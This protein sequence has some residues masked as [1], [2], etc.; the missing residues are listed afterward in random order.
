MKDTTYMEKKIVC[1][2]TKTGKPIGKGFRFHVMES[3]LQLFNEKDPYIFRGGFKTESEALEA[4][5][6]LV[7]MERKQND[8]VHVFDTRKGQW[9]WVYFDGRLI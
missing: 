6:N 8:R 3:C 4:R 1:K 9:G 2:K 5:E 7:S